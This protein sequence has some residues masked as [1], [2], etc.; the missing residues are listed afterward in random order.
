MWL[1]GRLAP[2]FKT[3]ADF[4]RDN[5][6]AIRKVCVQFVNLCRSIGLF[7]SALVVIDG[8]KFKAVNNRDKNFTK[9]KLSS[10]SS[11]ALLA[12]WPSWTERTGTHRWSRK[13]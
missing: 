9:H 1:T 6:K 8:S 10:S 11:K 12:I 4:R 3:I 2:D 5:G 13:R 7:E